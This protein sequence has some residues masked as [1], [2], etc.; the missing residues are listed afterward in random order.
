MI[1]V[2][3][4][5]TGLPTIHAV[6]PAIAEHTIWQGTPSYINFALNTISLAWSNVAIS[7]A[8]II[9]FLMMLGPRPVHKPFNLHKTIYTLIIERSLHKHQLHLCIFFHGLVFSLI[10][11]I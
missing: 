5:S 10:L 7:A 4:T 8:F 1:L 2:L 6:N 11:G 9:E 3:R